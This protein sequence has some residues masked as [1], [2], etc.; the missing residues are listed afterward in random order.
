MSHKYDVTYVMSY[1]KLFVRNCNL[2]FP[3]FHIM[4][5]GSDVKGLLAK[6]LPQPFWSCEQLQYFEIR[7]GTSY[8]NCNT[9]LCF[10]FH[11]EMPATAFLELWAIAIAILY[12]AL[13][14]FRNVCRSLFWRLAIGIASHDLT[15]AF[16]SDS[17]LVCKFAWGLYIL[18][19]LCPMC[20]LVSLLVSTF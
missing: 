20:L 13:L 3:T 14:L 10:T 6:C 1:F 11:F 2:S 8:C 16:N 12:F 15:D 7:S 4:W 18:S 5:L 17:L 19:L 9:L